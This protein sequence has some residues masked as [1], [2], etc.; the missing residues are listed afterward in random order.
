MQVRLLTRDDVRAA[1]GMKDAIAAMGEAFVQLS[2][3]RADVPLRHQLRTRGGITLLMP[4]YLRD[5]AD[6]GLKV[7]S[8]NEGNAA[9][10]LPV[11]NAVVLVLDPDT[12]LP[13]A[14]MDGTWLTALR[15]G[16]A[17]G[18]ATRLLAREDATVVAL[19]GAGVQARTQ[20]EAVRAVRPIREVRIVSR[21]AAAARRLAAELDGVTPRVMDDAAAAVR[22]A[23]V[24]ITATTSTAPVFPGAA[25]EPGTHVNAIGAYTPE[26][27]E[28]DDDA[29]RSAVL[30]VDSREAAL[31]EPG[32]IVIPIRSGAITPSH[33]RAELGEVAAGTRPGR[34]SEDEITVFKSVGSAV[35][36]IVIARLVLRAAESRGLGTLVEL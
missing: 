3:G 28:L 1:V 16:A 10:G 8:V 35:Q 31:S 29:V 33:I 9:R 12:G 14:L 13:L 15:T 5:T 7:V 19:F 18:L 6:L 32:D 11:V 25:L 24:V 4:A 26:M 27:R 20:L 2:T 36:D 17:S 22:G 30:V 34:T 23:H 21:T